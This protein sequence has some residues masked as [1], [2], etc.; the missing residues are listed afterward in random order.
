ML[1]QIN[2]SA[3]Q[4]A[5]NIEAEENPPPAVGFD[6]EAYAPWDR[7]RWRLLMAMFPI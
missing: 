7:S 1:V 3:T 4:K 6:C 5:E 2:L